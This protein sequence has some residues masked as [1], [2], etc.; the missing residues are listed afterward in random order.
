ML[1]TGGDIFTV[2]HS[3]REFL[4]FAALLEAHGIQCIAD[5]RRFPGSRRYPQFGQEALKKA[6]LETGIKYHWFEAL[7]GRRSVKNL[8]P[9]NDAWQVK[10]FHAYA[11]YLQTPEF[12]RA[13]D[14]LEQLARRSRTAYMCAEAM[15]TRCHRRLISDALVTRGWHVFHI[16]AKNAPKAHELTPFARVRRG[17][18]TYPS[19]EAK[20][21]LL[22]E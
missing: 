12:Q 18:L 8:S 2:G 10:A 16:T 13:L 14:K 17:R 20:Q 4:N 11:D 3:T 22:F 7:G 21:P 15:W 9:E 5:V 6:L 1:R 19:T